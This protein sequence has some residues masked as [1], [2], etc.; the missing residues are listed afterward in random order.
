MNVTE[1]LRT[2][3]YSE[4][5]IKVEKDRV[6]AALTKFK[7]LKDEDIEKGISNLKR[8]LT[9][10]AAYKLHGIALKR[11]TDMMLAQDEGKKLILMIHEEYP[12]VIPTFYNALEREGKPRNIVIEIPETVMWLLFDAR[13][14]DKLPQILAYGEKHGMDITAAH[15]PIDKLAFG[16]VAEG[17]IP[18]PDFM[19]SGGMFCDQGPKQCE[20]MGELFDIPYFITTDSTRD[21]PWGLYP[22]VDM[23]NVVYQGTTTEMH[24]Q[25]LGKALGL[26]I[27]QEDLHKAR[28]DIVK[29]WAPMQEVQRLIAKT[30]PRP[31]SAM[32]DQPFYWMTLYPDWR[33]E[34]FQ[35][36]YKMLISEIKEKAAKG[37]G[38]VPK[39]APRT[40]FFCDPRPDIIEMCEKEIGINLVVLGA[41]YW[42]AP[43][44]RLTRSLPK[45]ANQYWRFAESY[46]KRGMVRACA[47]DMAF[48]AVEY[49]R[50]FKLDGWMNATEYGCRPLCWPG[51]WIK[52]EVEKEIER[53]AGVPAIYFEHS[54]DPRS[55]T[56]EQLRTKLET[57]ASMMRSR[58][59]RAQRA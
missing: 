16:C 28:V 33:L 47:W 5:E 37:E 10:D 44:E 40:N 56:P 45:D 23:D 1:L 35:E 50:E 21:E 17:I 34:E 30:E 20:I 9:T 32:D 22:E 36:A 38:V 11:F 24:F 48:R 46:Q 6:E 51:R 2:F 52:E 26:E 3:K 43:Y 12:Q 58:K 7:I 18:K 57:F 4:D 59:A 29:L 54:F 49:V 8:F 25:E 31:V 27:T 53:G 19:T 55:H 15:C 41:Y 14:F 13:C 42:I 39:G